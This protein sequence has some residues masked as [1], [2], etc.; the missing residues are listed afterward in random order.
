MTFDNYKVH[1]NEG[2]KYKWLYYY[3]LSNVHISSQYYD[4]HLYINI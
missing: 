3:T 4:T 1:N 2:I